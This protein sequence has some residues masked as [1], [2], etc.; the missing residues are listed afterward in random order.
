MRQM[1]PLRPAN[2]PLAAV[3]SVYYVNNQTA[4]RQWQVSRPINCITV[5]VLA[6]TFSSSGQFGPFAFERAWHALPIPSIQ[7]A[8]AVARWLDVTEATVRAWVSGRRCPPRAVVY[9]LWL[10]SAE[11]RQMVQTDLFN[12]ARTHAAHAR[13]LQDV[14]CRQQAAIA[15]LQADLSAAKQLSLIHI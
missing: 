3:L 13:S 5:W 6:M 14:S 12:E 10:E 4:R 9:A 7:R 11:G 8:A 2:L 15:A 1:L